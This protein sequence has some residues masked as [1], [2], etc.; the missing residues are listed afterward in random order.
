MSVRP[1]SCSFPQC[2]RN[3]EPHSQACVQHTCRQCLCVCLPGSDKCNNHKCSVEHCDHNRAVSKPYCDHHCCSYKKC[4]D[5]RE[6][7]SIYCFNH[8]CL[9]CSQRC[10]ISSINKHFRTCEEHKCHAGMGCNEDGS[11]NGYCRIHTCVLQ[12]CAEPCATGSS[13][14][15]KHTCPVP[16]CILL[17]LPIY[18]YQHR[19]VVYHC[20]NKRVDGQ[21]VC[22]LH[23]HYCK[24][25]G[26]FKPH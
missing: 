5:P 2:E 19:C 9:Y 13:Y 17:G 8:K 10:R 24:M 21:E 6:D 4:K 20:N 18:C 15:V 3:R 12:G 26:C 7:S 1:L 23:E 11:S 22:E 16:T 25:D 14:C